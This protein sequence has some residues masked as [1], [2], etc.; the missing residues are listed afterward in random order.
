MTTYRGNATT[1]PI[2]DAWAFQAT[3]ARGRIRS[4]ENH[5]KKKKKQ[6]PDPVGASSTK[7]PKTPDTQQLSQADTQQG[8]ST[9][10]TQQLSQTDTQQ[11]CLIPDTQDSQVI[12]ATIQPLSPR[13]PKRFKKNK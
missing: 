7:K 11:D 5:Q 6:T 3:K 8:K 10:D 2:V 4:V 9:P 13:R 12:D 1:T